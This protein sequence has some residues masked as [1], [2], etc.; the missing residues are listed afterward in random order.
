LVLR[1]RDDADVARNR[2]VRRSSAPRVRPRARSGNPACRFNV[3]EMYKAKEIMGAARPGVFK[4]KQATKLIRHDSRGRSAR[5]CIFDR[6][7]GRR[8]PP[9]VTD[10]EPAIGIVENGYAVM[11][12]PMAALA[13]SLRLKDEDHLVL[14]QMSAP[15][16]GCDP[17]S[18]Q[19][20]GSRFQTC[21]RMSGKGREPPSEPGTKR[22][23]YTT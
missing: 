23:I 9:P 3:H 16:R 2:W 20:Q 22:M 6:T 4:A 15:G 17:L 7:N 10:R 5:R 8:A 11:R 19:F 18:R 13:C 21:C 12:L 1:R 14:L